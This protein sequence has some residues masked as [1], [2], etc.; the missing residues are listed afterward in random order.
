[1]IENADNLAL[2]RL[3]TVLCASCIFVILTGVYL[4]FL[5]PKSIK[6]RFDNYVTVQPQQKKTR[7]RRNDLA[8]ARTTINRTLSI[9]SSAALKQRISSAYWPIT[10]IEFILI[11][12]FATV[13]GFFLGWVIPGNILGGVA[14]AGVAFLLP[15]LFLTN[16]IFA[17]Q[18]KFQNQLVDV[19]V[20][21]TGAV[22]SG[23]S[24]L[25]SLDVVVN[26]MSAP[27]SEEFSRVLREIQFGL[28]LRQAFE[29]LAKR[30]QSDDLHLVVTA[31]II[32]SQVGGNLTTML[33][34][35]TNTIRDRVQLLGEVRS[36]TSY[37][38]YTGYML[39]AMPFITALVIFLISPDYFSE[40]LRSPIVQIIFV[41]AIISVLIG[42]LWLRFLIRIDV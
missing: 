24:L 8:A 25:Q 11:R 19:L 28:P 1:M 31:I 29:N 39:T 33:L 16:S 21:I 4:I 13:I 37:A 34:A 14:L 40:A 22:R 17:R 27:A 10:D 35:V 5:Q 30:M 12:L 32:N 2:L 41:G 20:L 23:Y 15:N 42:N 9:F 7:S 36:L 38:T 26:E 6:K 18:R 3:V